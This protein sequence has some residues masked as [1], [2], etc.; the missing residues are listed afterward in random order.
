MSKKIFTSLCG[1]VLLG[2]AASPRVSFADSVTLYVDPSSG[3]PYDFSINGSSKITDLSCLNDQRQINVGESWTATA[4]NLEVMINDAGITKNNPDP[5][6]GTLTLT[7]LQEDA[8]LDSLYTST[9]TSAKNLEIQDAI[10]TILDKK[11]A[12]NPSSYVYTNLPGWGSTLTA[13]ETAV[14]NY[15]AA[16]IGSLTNPL[17]DTSSTL[18]SRSTRPPTTATGARTTRAARFLRNS[19][20]TAR[21][22]PSRQV[23]SY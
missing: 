1:F 17:Y 15:Y 20:A 7:E 10:W 18:S 14:Q 5:T 19:S 8:Y 4:E 2:F 11:G 13:E 6:D 9:D 16:A 21:R 22:L 12:T 23:L 3:S